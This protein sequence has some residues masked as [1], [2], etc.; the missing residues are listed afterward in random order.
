LKLEHEK[1]LSN[2]AFK[3]NLRRFGVASAAGAAADAALL[4]CAT[5]VVGLHPDEATEVSPQQFV[6]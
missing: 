4:A 1:T 3:F 2:Y 6:Q 5:F